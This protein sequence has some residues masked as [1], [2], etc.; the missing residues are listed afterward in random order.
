MSYVLVLGLVIG[1]AG[2][3]AMA[4]DAVSENNPIEGQQGTDFVVD[5][6]TS[7]EYRLIYAGDEKLNARNTDVLELSNDEG[8][9]LTT[10]DEW[11]N[12]TLVLG[13]VIDDDLTTDFTHGSK[14]NIIQHED[15]DIVGGEV[16]SRSGGERLQSVIIRQTDP[17]ELG[18]DTDLSDILVEDPTA[19]DSEISV[20][21]E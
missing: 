8:T 3:V 2:G 11:T 18:G 16:E 20:T 17:E 10:P 4:F 5:R 21:V 1:T 12:Q 15:A 9:I 7:D 14:I 13:D 6:T 19:S